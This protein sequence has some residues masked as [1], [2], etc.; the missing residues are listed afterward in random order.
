MAE[1][2][3]I[4]L[5]GGID[6]R[7]FREIAVTISIAIAVSALV[8]LTLTPMMCSQLLTHDDGNHGRFYRWTEAGFDWMSNGYDRA[9]GWVLRH[10][11]LMQLVTLATV[12]L[13]VFLFIIIPKGLFPQQD[14]GL[15]MGQ[16]DAPQDVSF[17]SMRDR[18]VAVN[19]AVQQDPNIGHIISFIGR[20]GGASGNT[21][22][23]FV[24]LNRKP[25]RTE[26]ADDVINKLRP[27]IAKVEG[28]KLFLQAIQDVRVGGRSS[29]SQYQYTLQ[30]ADLDELRTWAPK[31]MAV[32]GKLPELKDVNT[33][34]Q[35]QGLQ[36]DVKMDRDTAARLGLSANDVDG[37]LYDAFGQRQVATMYS[38]LNQYRVV[39]EVKPKYTQSVDGLNDIY[40]KGQ[41][42]NTGLVPL[43]AIA[44][45]SESSTSLSITHQGQFPCITLSFNLSPGVSLG[46]AVE[47][48]HKAELE[49]GLPPSIHG[50]FS[51]TA[52]A[53]QASLKTQPYLIL[54]A[55]VAVYIVLGMLYESLIHPLTIL[56][57]LPSAGVGALLALLLFK[58]DFSIIALIGII[59][60]IGIVKKNAI[61]MIDFAL[62][63][64]RD[65][66]LSP[67]ESIHRACVLRF[68]PIMMT[69]LAALFGGLPLAF[70]TGMGAEMRRPLGI[71][72][73]GGLIVSQM[74]TL[75][76]TPVIY[77]LMAPVEAF[78]RRLLG[79]G[80]KEERVAA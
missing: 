76:T 63:V 26:T 50:S 75:F 52:E 31:L 42:V 58:T 53:F 25:P 19:N 65:E 17:I 67:R 74:L 24:D 41:S 15:L 22:T 48:V 61:M 51:G 14:T 80:V 59:L 7:L 28:V 27:K 55:L 40:V 8:S 1:F 78:V 56:S 30:D 38:A 54:A 29:R 35:T 2:I 47:S 39:L 5:I 37:A 43:P 20:G 21:G 60:L 23:V 4:L 68:R 66:G 72:I 77:L 9:L 45:F 33:D 69:T 71:A 34:Q 13:T 6:G 49:L 3:P 18:Q 44:K 12:A 70:G 57:T 32:L 36:L 11:V 46:E 62:E 16:S 64:E 73:V 10:E 79:G